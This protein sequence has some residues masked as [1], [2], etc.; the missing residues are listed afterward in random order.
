MTPR[1]AALAGLI[2]VVIA[3]IYWLAPYVLGG[4]VDYAGMTML[5]AL[6]AAVAIMAYVLFTGLQRS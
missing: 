6:G 2:F 4:I 1:R 3:G 5:I